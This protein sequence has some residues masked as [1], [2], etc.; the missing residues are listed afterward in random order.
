MTDFRYYC[1]CTAVSK[2]LISATQESEKVHTYLH[3]LT[4]YLILSTLF[5]KYF[6]SIIQMNLQNWIIK[7]VWNMNWIQCS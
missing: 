2:K 6:F 3:P 1:Y 5:S 4:A 7:Y